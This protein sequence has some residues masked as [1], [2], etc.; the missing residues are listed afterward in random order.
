[1]SAPEIYI[2]EQLQEIVV[3]MLANDD[4]FV[5]NQSANGQPI[6]IITENIGDLI[7]EIDKKIASTGICAVVLTP[8]FEFTNEWVSEAGGIALDG[9][10]TI[11]VGIF[12]NVTLNQATSGTK[13][14]AIA[15]AQ[16]V[17]RLLH[18]Q[19]TGL[20]DNPQNPS[21]LMGMKR[22][23]QLTSEGPPLNY[24]V[25]FQAHLSLYTPSI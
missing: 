8:L 15:V 17:L 3:G 21:H 9:L 14:R 19:P 13:I 20:P 18:G 24:S 4:M 22:P 2:L 10:G 7:T 1:M 6:P 5:G 11:S 25:L 12:E 23:L 16:R